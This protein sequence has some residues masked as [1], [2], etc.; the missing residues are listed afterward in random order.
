MRFSEVSPVHQITRDEIDDIEKARRS[1]IRRE[2]EK[3]AK[4]ANASMSVH[5]V[6][7]EKQEV[8]V[9]K[10]TIKMSP[11]IGRAHV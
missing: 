11:Q 7:V 9:K 6:V 8:A 3:S 5:V 2:A 4:G 10:V 1:K